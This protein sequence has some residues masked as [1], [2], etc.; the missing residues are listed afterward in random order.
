[1]DDF[2]FECVYAGVFGELGHESCGDG[3]NELLSEVCWGV[4]D[5]AVVENEVDMGGLVGVV[6]AWA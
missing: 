6:S 4:E 3:V 2:D 1:M 5:S